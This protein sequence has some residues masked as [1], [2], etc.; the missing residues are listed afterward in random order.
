M[1]A[2]LNLTLP[3]SQ[4]TSQDFFDRVVGRGIGCG[5]LWLVINHCVVTDGY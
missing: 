2:L 1:K 4:R 3:L 5:Y